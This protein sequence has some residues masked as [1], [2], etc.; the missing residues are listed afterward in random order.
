MG[1]ESKNALENICEHM[2]DNIPSKKFPD[3]N[4]K[5]DIPLCISENDVRDMAGAPGGIK[6]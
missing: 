4:E 6:E 2:R 5:V 3:E 1:E